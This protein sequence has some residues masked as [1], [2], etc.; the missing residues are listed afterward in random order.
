MG[1]EKKEKDEE[2]GWIDWLKIKKVYMDKC[3]L[4]K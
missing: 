3:S 1:K 2:F 4:E